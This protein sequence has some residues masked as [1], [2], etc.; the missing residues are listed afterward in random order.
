MY[1]N[2]DFERFYFHYQTEALPKGISM[3]VFC[4]NNHVPYNLFFKWY[5]DTRKKLVE[6]E[7]VGRPSEV[8][9]VVSEAQASVLPACSSVPRICIELRLSN[10]LYLS[11]KNLSCQELVRMIEKLEGLC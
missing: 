1:S 10:G 6:V 9:S 5:K 7:V 4:Q 2:D 11:Q 8:P 3:Q